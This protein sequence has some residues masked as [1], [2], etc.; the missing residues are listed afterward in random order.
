MIKPTII[1]TGANGFIGEQLVHYFFVNGWS[2]KAFVRN[3]PNEIVRDV[4]YVEYS[5]ERHLNESAFESVDYLVHCAYLRFD[6]NNDADAINI[7]GTKRLIAICR[8]KNIKPL[9]LSSFSA[10]KLAES[11]YGKTKL[12]CEH[13]FDLAIDVVLKPGFVI[14]KKGL[15]AELIKTI[16]ST[17]FFPLISAGIQPIQTIHIDDLCQIIALAFTRNI[18]GLFYIAEPEAITMKVFY[19]EVA[20]QLNK[21]LRFIYFPLPLLFFICKTA[22]F[23]GLHL[24]V[25]SESVLGLKHLLKFETK[26]DLQKFDVNIMSYRESLQSVLK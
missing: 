3:I 13:L 18:H 15:A 17:S 2:V 23:M 16:R 20:H 12:A 9:F 4:E 5:L 25:S 26:D 14:G 11:H 7:S 24:R 10:H 19:Q 21:K 1:I 22:E 8:K 6:E